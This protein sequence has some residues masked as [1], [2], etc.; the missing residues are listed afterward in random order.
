MQVFESKADYPHKPYRS[1][2][3][4]REDVFRDQQGKW[5][6]YTLW[7]DLRKLFAG[8]GKSTGDEID[9][10]NR[11]VQERIAEDIAVDVWLGK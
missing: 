2:V 4:N 9:E 11:R 5:D 10:H 6:S 3:V 1:L 8:N 7:R